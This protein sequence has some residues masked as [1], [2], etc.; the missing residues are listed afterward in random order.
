[1][2]DFLYSSS[3]R[4]AAGLAS[5]L[6]RISR[7]DPPQVTMFQG[8]WGS[9]AVTENAYRGF[10][11]LETE[12]RIVIVIGGPVLYFASNSF[13]AGGQSTA[14]TQAIHDRF[15]AGAMRWDDD[16]SGPF[17]VLMIDK[18]DGVV[19]CVTDLLSFIPVYSHRTEA[20]LALGTHE[21]AL[22][23]YTGCEHEIDPVSVTDFLLHTVVTH[24]YTFYTDIRQ[25]DPAIVYTKVRSKEKALLS[26]QEPYWEP[27]E[28]RL[29]LSVEDA[30][31]HAREALETYM[32]RLT[33]DMTTVAQFLS[34]GEDSRVI[35][36]LLPETLERQGYVFV[37]HPNREYAIAQR[38]ART[39]N[40]PL[41][42]TF[43]EPDHYLSILEETLG[44]VGSGHQYRHAHTARLGR[45]VQLERYTALFCGY[46]ANSLL[47]GT[48]ARFAQTHGSTFLRPATYIPEESRSAPIVHPAF[49]EDIRDA[50]RQRRVAHVR[51]VQKF[52][53]SG[54]H[55]WF[56]LWPSSMMDSIGG[57]Y[58]NRRLF[59]VYH[60]FMANALTKVS[61]AIPT[62]WKIRRRL[63]HRLAKPL[64]YRTRHIRHSDG[65]YPYWSWGWNLG[66]QAAAI[67]WRRIKQAIGIERGNQGSWADWDVLLSG[68]KWQ[69]MASTHALSDNM[70]SG[71]LNADTRSL[72]TGNQ[73]SESQKVNLIQVCCLLGRRRP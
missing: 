12:R 66:P 13:L 23:A 16:V 59:R 3:P 29:F 1:M 37:D 11:P 36:A 57:L 47:K 60:P 22:A 51:A 70:L 61:A 25:L 39:H 31:I 30:A 49:R 6:Q 54:V 35:A 15:Q 52:R 14:G 56:D 40:M 43:R 2:S 53:E 38:V 63:F 7:K 73:L 44:L 48:R 19:R 65:W 24:P 28:H 55:E 8:D 71:L 42:T 45:E 10:Q 9:L 67:Y 17:V 62:E 26:H 69:E 20:V 21:D 4:Q 34:G 41:H 33:A 32:Q 18:N 50:V 68:K 64:L 58:G 72:M 5:C 27:R 46:G